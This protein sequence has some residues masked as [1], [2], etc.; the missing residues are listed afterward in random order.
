MK[1]KLLIFIAIASLNLSSCD[2]LDIVPDDT[3]TLSDAFKN[4][5]TTEGFLYS[6][7]SYIPRYNDAR[8]NFS[9]IMSDETVASYHW[10]TQWFSFL[11][12]QQLEY[13]AADPVLD[14][15][16]NSY[17]GIRQCHLFLE[18]VDKA[19]PISIS[20]DDFENKKKLWKAEANFLLAYYH[21]VLL[22]NYGP[23][24]IVDNLIATDAEGDE[25]NK[26]RSPYDECVTYIANK[27]DLASTDLP[28]TIS[29]RGD[30][31]R[32]TKT[33]AQA[34]KSRMYVFAA[35]PL[36]NGNKDYSDFKNHDGT[37]L[38]SQNYDKEKW[39]KAMDETKKAIE[40]AEAS[41]HKL[42][43]YTK[44]TI[45]TPFEQAV[46]N[47]RWQM[48]D[49]W[50]SE[51]I[52]GYSANKEDNNAQFSF[53]TLA[54]PRGWRPNPPVGGVG[55]TL[56]AVEL[57]YSKNGIPAEK[58]PTYDWNNRYKVETIDGVETIKLHRNREPRF[59]AYIGYD[60]GDYE[61]NNETR[62]L[63]LRAGEINGTTLNNG[64]PRSDVDHLYSG[65]A[66]KK[67]IHPSTSVTTNSLSVTAYP[68]PIIRL[69][70]LY[71]NYAE[72][73]AN[74]TGTLDASGSKYIN[75]IR[76]R[77]GIPTLESA[78]NGALSGASL[79]KAIQRERLIEMMFEGHSLYDRRRWKTAVDDYASSR[80]GMK[81]LTAIGMTAED[82]Y[83]PRVLS[84]RPLIFDTKQYLSPIK[85]EYI[86]I[87]HNL[88]QNPG[89]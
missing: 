8:T 27:F 25:F 49:P 30:F 29:D 52:W 36:F 31:G 79:V 22:Q 26:P 88:V 7:Y 46:M 53:Q 18:N 10:G 9:W 39:K 62:K 5:S 45:N 57:F 4:E 85:T 37:L 20:K 58:D 23:I 72:A 78:H 66:I 70:E 12:I 11:R 61:I 75:A 41:G 60:R 15:W 33:I 67:G 77:A 34:L 47:T 43:E 56:N 59:Y 3:P 54:I 14:I 42:Y 38:I 63:E 73:V 87:N 6:C 24:V 83:K 89:W 13:S 86:K 21:Y 44:S 76:K 65:Y 32:A 2:Y 69:G 51:L 16:Q 71:L 17:K 40:Q 19:R 74:Y 1:N 50:N 68:F 84:G 55:A 64:V 81:G 48:V 80:N 28:T 35:S 82:F